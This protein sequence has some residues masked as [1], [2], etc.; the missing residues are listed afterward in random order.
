MGAEKDVSGAGIGSLDGEKPLKAKQRCEVLNLGS[1]KEYVFEKMLE[2]EAN[3][4]G[5]GSRDVTLFRKRFR[6]SY[7]VFR[8]LMRGRY[9]GS[10]RCPVMC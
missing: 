5:L 10:W 4:L 1:C 3:L 6:A 2:H 7:Q 8:K 9:R